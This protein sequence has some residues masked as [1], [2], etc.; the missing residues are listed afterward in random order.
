MTKMYKRISVA[1]LLATGLLANTANAQITGG[2]VTVGASGTYTTFAAFVTA[3]NGATIT[4]PVIVNVDAGLTE[5]APPTGYVITATGT[6]TNTITIQKAGAGANP[7]LTAQVGSATPASANPDGVV[8][9]AGGD[10]ITFD[11]IDIKDNNTTNPATMEYGYGFFKA[12]A[13]DGAQYN[14]IKNCNITL[15]RINN[16]VATSPMI[17]GSVGVA[18]MNSAY[19]AAVTVITVTNATGTNSYNKLDNNIIRNVNYGVGIIGFVATSPFTNADYGNQVVN[20]KIYNFGGGAVANASAGIRTLAQYDLAINFNTLDNNLN[21]TGTNHATTF[22][23]VY[24]NTATSANVTINGNTIKL[25]GAATVS[26]LTAIESAAGSTAAGNTV[27]ITN[28]IIDSCTYTTATSGVFTGIL[29]SGTPAIFNAS[30][31]TISNATLAGTGTMPMISVA[32][33]GVAI[34]NNNTIKNINRTSATGGAC[35][36]IVVNSP[37]TSF[38]ANNNIIDDIRFSNTASVGNIDG[39]YSFSSAT[40]VTLM[41]NTIKNLATP[42]TGLLQ[43]IREFGSAGRK[44]I[45]NNTIT[46]FITTTGGAGGATINGIYC[47][48]GDIVIKNNT[49]SNLNSTGTTGGTAGSINGIFVSAGVTDS[50]IGNKI[51]NLSTA[52][53][54]TAGSVSGINIGGNTVNNIYN[55]VIGNIYAP[56]INSTIEAVRGITLSS[57]TTN[58]TINVFY[59]TI[60]LDATSTATNFGATGVQHTTSAAA[61]TAT[62]NL[63][64]NVIVNNSVPNGTGVVSALRRSNN[65]LTNFGSASN[66]NLLYAG[67]PSATRAILYDGTTATQTL[68]TYQTLVASR[69]TSS[70]TENVS[71]V[72]TVGTMPTF[73]Q[74]DNVTPTFTE[75]GAVNIGGIA[76]DFGGITR[77]GNAGYA[78]TGTAPDMGAYEFNGVSNLPNCAG[79][80][81]VA[82]SLASTTTAC[83]GTMFG[84]SLSTNYSATAGITYQWQSSPDSV[85]FT[86]IASANGATLTTSETSTTYYQCVVTCTNSSLST[87]S[88][89]IKVGLN[90]FLNC[91]CATTYTNGCG[92]GDEITNVKYKTI[93]NTSSCVAGSYTNYPTPNPTVFLGATDTMRISFGTDNNQ[94]SGVWIDFNQDGDFVDAG[95]FVANTVATP[96]ASGTSTLL[97]AI[98]TT[99]T[100]GTTK[101]RIRGGNDNVLANTPCGVSSSGYGETE[102]YLVTIVCP[103]MAGATTTNASICTGTT[104]TLTAMPTS[105]GTLK[106]YTDTTAGTLVKIGNSYTTSTLSADTVLWVQENIAAS[107]LS[108]R[109]KVNVTIVQVTVALTPVNV[110]CNG[111]SNG[112]F[113]LGTIT[114]GT[115]PF[116]YSVDG[117]AFG[118]IPTNLIAGTYSVIAK[119]ATNAVSG[120]ISVV[121]TQPSWIVTTPTT[122]NITVCEGATMANL[123]AAAGNT[124]STVSDSVIIPFNL[125]AQPTELAASSSAPSIATY[126][127]VIATATIAALPVGSAITNVK[128]KVP[129]LVAN[130]PSW[131]A[132]VFLALTG[133]ISTVYAKDS[134]APTSAGTFNYAKY[135]V[136][137]ASLITGGNVNLNYFESYNDVTTGA[138]CT[139]PL[140]TGVITATVY[141]TKPAPANITW[142]DAL[143]GG[144]LLGSND[145]INA[146]G[147]SVLP[148]SLTPGTYNFYANGD[149]LG[150]T[151]AARTLATVTVNAKPVAPVITPATATI[152]CTGNSVVI[153]SSAATNNIWSTAATTPTIT[154]ATSGT[155]YSIVTSAQGCKSDTSNKVTVIVNTKPATP[156]VTGVATIC[157]GDTAMLASNASTGNMWS[158]AS[159]AMN[160]NT[161]TAGTYYTIV[162]AAN[163]CI[164]DTS[165]KVTVVVNALPP[166]PVVSGTATICAGDTA[167]LMSD[168]TT[169]NMWSNGSTIANVNTTTVGTYYTI[170]TN[171]NGCKSD[172]SNLVT[173]IVNALP[174]TPVVTTSAT[175]LCAGDT[176]MLMSDATTGNMWSNTSTTANVNA[177]TAGTYYTIVTNVNGC[178]SD[179]SNLVTIVVN[180]L[181]P[182]PVVT[183]NSTLCAG[184]TATLTSSATTGN[185]WSDASTATNVTTTTAGNYYTI[186]TDANGCKSDTSNTVAVVVN[187]LPA[188]P[189]VTGNGLICAGATATLTSSATTGNMW[190]DA[191]A[192]TNVTTS[193][194]GNYYTIVTD[195]NGCTSDTSNTVAVVVNALPNAPVIVA[196]SPELNCVITKDTLSASNYTTGLMWS[197]GASTATTIVTSAGTYTATHTDVNGC[198]SATSNSLTII[199]NT[200]ISFAIIPPT[201]ND[202]ICVGGTANLTVSGNATT[203]TWTPVATLNTST[204]TAVTATPTA[205][206]TYVVTAQNAT[207]CSVQDSVT[208]TIVPNAVVNATPLSAVVTIT[209]GVMISNPVTVTGATTYSFTSNTSGVATHQALVGSNVSANTINDSIGGT[210]VGNGTVV[211][212]IIGYNALGCP[213]P[214]TTVT[215]NVSSITALANKAVDASL[216]IYPN[217]TTDVVT[218]STKAN[219]LNVVMINA[220]GSIVKQANVIGNTTQLTVNDLAS[221]TYLLRITTEAGTTVKQVVVTK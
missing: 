123:I 105:S 193:T 96:G 132:D 36:G 124:Q 76:T 80:P 46:N 102:D 220:N 27:A 158:N 191:S 218:I 24:I 120:A 179:T 100:I 77:Q 198:T 63:N 159:T 94:Y 182:T 187:A 206:T 205:T 99:A 110:S 91:Y 101:M 147:T 126:P 38:T 185:I 219:S 43:G 155:Y 18:I 212:T 33:P 153:N 74:I 17:E 136:P 6:F 157:A 44:L 148:T 51:Y 83:S 152:F 35:R 217:P 119:D 221:G 204:G 162:T 210:A 140:G 146:I 161:T 197:N 199:N 192:A 67:T 53:T 160:V 79:T 113:A 176:S 200:G 37:T 98:P 8:K 111:G 145:T 172:T 215:V 58:S 84:L 139:F 22:R 78:G 174:T 202:S 208:I 54:G 62:L 61:T 151:A 93:N 127:N 55:N 196:T 186:V 169:G 125:T 41:G 209:D 195:A 107:C 109:K 19:N 75:S 26:A 150:C 10:Y 188:T 70:K 164:S 108:P 65:V 97:I 138:D 68:T 121:I 129:N 25:K 34:A 165:N 3:L 16:A 143:T 42:T 142:F 167:M 178:K 92:S 115:A 86:N 211:Y 137:T 48:T 114:C 89:A 168:A 149:A 4:G 207:G 11:G 45:V 95:E 40:A 81:A 9:I 213:G 29:N 166:T 135:F 190:S 57:T 128:I 177:T 47:S 64:N 106:W 154:V 14:T 71:F 180:T 66:N 52:S 20:N 118:P 170:V 156:V 175:T 214:A 73:L 28:N 50:I 7:L 49:V 189:V 72:S 21:G 141:Y 112:S 56:K 69:E 184:D 103:T 130:S 133:N 39:I 183:G 5:T 90:S 104:A 117:G 163:G 122:T 144:N 30:D 31:N 116:I 85:T 59:N 2:T 87:I 203:Y 181:P 201:P 194:A 60:Y 131:R 171:G 82:N 1:M 134:L 88:A 173:V 13:T 15:N 216:T 23:G 12:S 32:S